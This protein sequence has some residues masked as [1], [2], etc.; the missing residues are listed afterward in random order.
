MRRRPVQILTIVL[1]LVLVLSAAGC[2][3]KKTTT[4]TTTT[5]TTEATTTAAATTTEAASTETTTT[6]STTTTASG[7]GL[8]ALASS[9]NCQALIGL[10]TAL[11]QAFSGSGANA[12]LGKE[13]EILKQF[14]DKAPAELKA[15]FTTMANAL[16]KIADAM[17]GYKPSAGK[18]PDAATIAKLQQLSAS[19][20]VQALTAASQHIA[21]WSAANCHG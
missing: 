21:T 16:G 20:D 6:E 18:V 7:T 14:A 4:T 15:D 2:G 17:K 3:K 1:S 9:S 11:S 8:G 19:L 12:D 5:T 13:A 10:G